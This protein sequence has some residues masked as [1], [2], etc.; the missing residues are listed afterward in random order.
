MPR[1]E[2]DVFVSYS[3]RDAAYAERL[4]QALVANG[5]SV[6]RDRTGLLA[7]Q[8]FPAALEHALES[9]SAVV[10]LISPAALDSNWVE[11]ER[12]YAIVLANRKDGRPRLISAIVGDALPP[13]FL[14]SRHAVD[15]RTRFEDGLSHLLRVLESDDAPP[16]AEAA[17]PPSLA[18]L[19]FF[20]E[21]LLAPVYRSL[22]ASR[23]IAK[24]AGQAESEGL[25]IQYR[26]RGAPLC[27]L[28]PGA[29]FY[30]RSALADPPGTAREILRHLD[31]E[32][33][34]NDVFLSGLPPVGRGRLLLLRDCLDLERT[35]SPVWRP[36]TELGRRRW[37][38]ARALASYA[39]EEEESR[40]ALEINQRILDKGGASSG[41][42]LLFHAR[43]LL[44][45]NESLQ[46]W[47]IYDVQ[48]G[49]DF[50]ADPGTD[51]RAR[52]SHTLD[53]AKA[54][55]DSGQGRTFHSEILS[56]YR[57]MLALLED[58]A[59]ADPC[60]WRALRA[61]LLN[62]KA[63]QLSVFGDQD[64][65]IEAQ[66]DLDQ[67][68]GL[69][70]DMG[71]TARALD[72]GSNVVAHTL[73][74]QGSAPEPPPGLS[75][76]VE[77][78]E[79]LARDLPAGPEVF[80]FLY[81]KARLL[82]RQGRVEDAIRAYGT[83]ARVAQNA[84]LE[85]RSAIAQRWVLRLAHDAGTLSRDRYVGDLEACIADLERQADAWSVNALR[86]ALRDLAVVLLEDNPP[87]AA[88][89]LLR[90]VRVEMLNLLRKR[91]PV[92]D[93]L[94]ELLSLLHGV[95]AGPLA[96]LVEREEVERLNRFLGLPD[97]FGLRWEDIEEARSR[98]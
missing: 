31:R 29:L 36:L 45:L 89:V 48:R 66:A 30:A 59:A 35:A 11:E 23:G 86:E 4:E 60:P 97:W 96:G 32:T 58:Q 41:R 50:F 47:A 52:I 73:D 56:G 80:F 39:L 82:R 22:V 1:V 77:R 18:W 25:L 54:A 55:K 72:V 81:Q 98:L 79:T 53:W 38:L 28:T 8:R 26:G 44:A 7:G 94:F 19:A 63:T 21:G 91:P 12:N 3:S 75:Q 49:A 15:L 78:L 2:H 46:A 83:A 17:V 16:P 5:L 40:L 33:E 68:E 67:A 76:R 93:R 90:A 85:S 37:D 71:E 10:F 43:I 95:R 87:K 20:P 84:Y 74:R 34:Q 92:L 9:S 6:F 65:W 51:L 13:G 70:A 24:D 62:N 69:Y 42:D 64:K 27:G 57:R 61:D 88:D 14:S